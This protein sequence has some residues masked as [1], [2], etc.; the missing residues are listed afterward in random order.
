M[1]TVIS[2]VFRC[3]LLFDRWDLNL[4]IKEV[5][6]HHNIATEKMETGL[7]TTHCLLE[8]N[9][10]V[11]NYNILHSR[12]ARSHL[13]CVRNLQTHT[14]STFQPLLYRHYAAV[15][16]LLGRD[17]G[18]CKISVLYSVELM[19]IHCRSIPEIVWTIYTLFVHVIS[20]RSTDLG[21]FSCVFWN[22][23]PADIL[24]TGDNNGYIP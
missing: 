24:L 2:V 8:T 1:C 9:Y 18:T 20:R 17:E 4:A 13:Q 11:F 5:D 12:V 19:T 16:L 7:G 23:F 22:A 14:C 10:C 3:D 15:C 6:S 21:N